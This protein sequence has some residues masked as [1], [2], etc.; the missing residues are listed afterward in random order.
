MKI[1]WLNPECTEAI[2]ERG[3]CGWKR[4]AHVA[5]NN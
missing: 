2:L 4:C 5:R 3:F 1:R